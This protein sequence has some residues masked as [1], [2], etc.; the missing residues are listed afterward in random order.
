MTV[1]AFT[2][3]ICARICAERYVEMEIGRLD[4]K[5][6]ILASRPLTESE[7]RWDKEAHE[8]ALRMRAA[9]LAYDDET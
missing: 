6:A 9:A 8:D 7:V 1:S 4:R 2:R 3:A 5:A